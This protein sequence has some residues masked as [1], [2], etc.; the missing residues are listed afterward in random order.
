MN[1]TVVYDLRTRHVHT[2]REIFQGESFVCD[3]ACTVP[4]CMGSDDDDDDFLLVYY[5]CQK[6]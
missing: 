1:E 3:A 6:R 4:L 2:Y 5:K